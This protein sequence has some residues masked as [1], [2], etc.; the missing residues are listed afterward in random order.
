MYSV[1]GISDVI[2]IINKGMAVC[3]RVWAVFNINK[4]K[5]LV[6]LWLCEICDIETDVGVCN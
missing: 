2:T 1:C 6:G 3:E 4:G 5:T